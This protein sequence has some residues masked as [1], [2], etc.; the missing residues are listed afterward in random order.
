MIL[1]PLSQTVHCLSAEIRPLFGQN[2]TFTIKTSA[3]YL[4]KSRISHASLFACLL[5]VGSLVTPWKRQ[6]SQTA[7]MVG[8]VSHDKCCEQHEKGLNPSRNKKCFDIPNLATFHFSL[9]PYV[10]MFW[11]NC[12]P[13]SGS[14]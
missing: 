7:V 6:M 12:I 2:H 3:S 13:K 8:S 14:L 11:V 10:E 4:D 5:W 1:H 9:G